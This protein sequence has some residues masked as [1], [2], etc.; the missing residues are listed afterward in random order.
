LDSQ[1]TIRLNHG[2]SVI[3]SGE[4]MT[5]EAFGFYSG[6]SI[7]LDQREYYKPTYSLG[8]RWTPL[9]EKQ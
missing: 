4:N 8:L 5:N 2:V 6:S 1:A 7:Y 3:V 9:R